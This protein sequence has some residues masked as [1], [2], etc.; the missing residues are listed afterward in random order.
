MVI[1]VDVDGVLVLVDEI[2]DFVIDITSIMPDPEV[3]LPNLTE[4]A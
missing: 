4:F 2:L 1:V 3:R